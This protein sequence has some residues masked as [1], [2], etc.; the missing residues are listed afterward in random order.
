MEQE[1]KKCP[2]CSHPLK[3]WQCPPETSLGVEYLYVC[4]NN[5][6]PYFLNGWDWMREKFNQRVS[7]RYRYNSFTDQSGPL[8]VWSK[9]ALRDYIVE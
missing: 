8:P 2:H 7:Y 6:C 3:K 1:I 9:D 4:F 5:E